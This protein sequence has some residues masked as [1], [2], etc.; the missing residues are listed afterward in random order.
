MRL[1]VAADGSGRMHD[2]TFPAIARLAGEAGPELIVLHVVRAASEAWSEDELQHVMA[3]RRQRLETLLADTDFEA[4]LLVEPLPYGG[5]VD[6]YIALRAVDLEVDAIVVASRRATGLVSGLL[7]SVAQGL[8]R[9]SPVP[10]IVV[11]PPDGQ[12]DGEGEGEDSASR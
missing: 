2:A 8:L 4:T 3:E 10:V 12:G 6:H 11:R 9:D 1:L 7:G 5:E